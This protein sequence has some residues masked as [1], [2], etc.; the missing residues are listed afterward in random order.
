MPADFSSVPLNLLTV[1]SFVIFFRG[2][3]TIAAPFVAAASR[4]NLLFLEQNVFSRQ[5]RSEIRAFVTC[6]FIT[7]IQ[8][9]A[10]LT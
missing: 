4:S 1:A 2:T 7:F 3:E 6:N 5:R 10:T 9:V 8:R